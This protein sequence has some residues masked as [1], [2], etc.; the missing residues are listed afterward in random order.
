MIK[1]LM[2]VIREV[3]TW[4]VTSEMTLA[5]TWSTRRG[6]EGEALLPN[7]VKQLWVDAHRA[8]AAAVVTAQSAV[9][10]GQME[11]GG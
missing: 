4:G 7:K 8:M 1:T 6:G 10:P 2:K 5:A 9:I 11:R 3:V